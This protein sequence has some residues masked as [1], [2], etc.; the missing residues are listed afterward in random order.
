MDTVR[1]KGTVLSLF[2]K[3]E[4]EA[5]VKRFARSHTKVVYGSAD[6]GILSLSL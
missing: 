4:T 5:L 3:G 1:E 6:N 2:Y